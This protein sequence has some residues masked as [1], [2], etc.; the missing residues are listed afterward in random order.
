MKCAAY[1]VSIEVKASR[2]S[3]QN[4]APDF[5]SA[6]PLRLRVNSLFDRAYPLTDGA[7]RHAEFACRIDHR[8]GTGDNVKSVKVS[9]RYRHI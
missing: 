6:T 7:G 5:V 1:A 3:C 8:P 2:M 4:A 9:D